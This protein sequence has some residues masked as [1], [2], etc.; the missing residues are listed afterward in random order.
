MLMILV[1]LVR[2]QDNNILQVLS[3]KTTQ[4][5][6][7][8]FK[9]DIGREVHREGLVYGIGIDAIKRE[10]LRHFFKFKFKHSKYLLLLFADLCVSL[11]QLKYLQISGLPPPPFFLF[12]TVILVHEH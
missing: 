1:K 7:K 12:T 11:V 9:D 4:L 8:A 3:L 5:S 10:V 2:L 6:S